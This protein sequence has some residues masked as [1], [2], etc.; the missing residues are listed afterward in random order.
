MAKAKTVKEV[1]EVK[2]QVEGTEE[3]KTNEGV[4]DN[5][6]AVVVENG[7]E[8]TE[9]IKDE[10]GNVVMKDFQERKSSIKKAK[11]P[12]TLRAMVKEKKN[13]R[14]DLAEQ[15]NVVWKDEQKSLFIHT[16]IYGYPF[17]TAFAVSTN[18]GNIWM[19]DGKQRT[20]TILGFVA[21]EWKLHKNTPDVFGVEI[22]GLKFSEL[23][24]EF[25]D[26]ILD[27]SFDIWE[28]KNMSNEERAE[29]FFRLNNGS[30]LTKLEVTRSMYSDLFAEVNELAELPFFA[31]VI[32]LTNSA[33]NRFVD[34]ELV[35]QIAMLL[36]EE[37][38][39]KGFGGNHVRDYVMGLKEHEARFSKEMVNCYKEMSQY[40]E[41]AFDEFTKK[42][43]TKALKKINVPMVFM[44]GLEAKK[45]GMKP[46]Q[47]GEF[48]KYFLVEIYDIDSKYGV[49]CQAGSAKKENVIIRLKEMDKAF[50]K[51]I[52]KNPIESYT[53]PVKEVVSE[54]ETDKPQ[55]PTEEEL[56][57]ELKEVAKEADKTVAKATEK[58]NEK[59]EEVTV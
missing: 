34:Q 40:L 5:M 39:L 41:E 25:R 35:V 21:D 26:E 45:L 38:K 7:I 43:T 28:M 42:D 37:Y 59:K 13:I 6:E 14:F 11:M 49:S 10:K 19:L 56:K 2:G 29:M 27:T 16:L 46:Q 47:F 23:P 1:K 20:T 48:V 44:Q 30:A 15:R 4:E 50:K 22:A 51:Y 36:D 54:G 3:V 52:K 9:E 55:A 17:P 58:K 18:D 24:E 12:M 53:I 8:S 57:A 32:S 33:R 31:D